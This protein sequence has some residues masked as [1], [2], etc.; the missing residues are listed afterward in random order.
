MCW[1]LHLSWCMLLGW[2]SRVWEISRVQVNWNCWSSCRVFLLLSILQLFPN[3]SRGISSFC[4]LVGC[5]Y[6][7][8]NILAAFWV[9]WRVVVIDFLLWAPHS[10]SNVRSSDLPLSWI[11]LCPVLYLLF[12]RLFSIYI[13]A[14]LSDRK[15]YG[16]EFWLCDRTPI[17]HLMPSLYW[18]WAQ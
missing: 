18:R 14:F 8:P 13:L 11:P 16:T 15:N 3:L 4:S 2:W 12:L 17:P 7:H 1:T 6:L 10:L 5:T 9:F